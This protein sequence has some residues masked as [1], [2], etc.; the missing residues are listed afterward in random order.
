MAMTDESKNS[1]HCKL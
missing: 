1:H